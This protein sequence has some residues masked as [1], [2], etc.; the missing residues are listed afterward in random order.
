MKEIRNLS[1]SV[2]DRLLGLAHRTQQPYDLVLVRYTLER[3]LYR[4]SCS[5]YSP[6]VDAAVR[7]GSS[8]TGAAGRF[9][10]QEPTRCTRI[11]TNQRHPFSGHVSSATRPGRNSGA[12]V[13]CDLGA[14]RA[15]ALK[16]IPEGLVD[17]AC[18]SGSAQGC[19]DEELCRKSR[20]LLPTPYFLLRTPPTTPPSLAAHR[21]RG[22]AC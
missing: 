17:Q 7:R 2:H 8:Q 19:G 15:M 10:P 16:T 11:D 9:R 22:P 6:R 4:L 12:R 20:P 5:E 1:H 14:W 13:R 18:H 3:L 21:W